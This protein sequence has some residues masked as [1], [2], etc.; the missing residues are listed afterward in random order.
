[1]RTVQSIKPD[2]IIMDVIM[3]RMDGIEACREVMDMLPAG[4]GEEAVRTV[5][6][7]KPDVIIMDHA[8]KSWTC[9]L[10]PEF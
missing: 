5:Q 2:V 6:S 4:D 3:P 9:Y 10:I 1:M 7:I 8:A